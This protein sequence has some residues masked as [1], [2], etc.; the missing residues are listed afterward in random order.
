[1]EDALVLARTSSVVKLVHRRDSFRASKVL[2]DR[3]LENPKIEVVWNAVVERFE[4]SEEAGMTAVAIKDV[5]TGAAS[6]VR[7]RTVLQNPPKPSKP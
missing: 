5:K 7:S 1:M 6:T 2:A 4:G 3:V